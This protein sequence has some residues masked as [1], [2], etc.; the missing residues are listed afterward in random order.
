MDIDVLVYGV[1]EATDT[2]D[3]I[4]FR[5]NNLDPVFR[6]TVGDFH[7]IEAQAFG[8]SPDLVQSGAL[9]D[10]LTGESADSF[11]EV[12]SDSLE[13]GTDIWYARFHKDR[14][15]APVTPAVKQKWGRQIGEYVA[16]GD[17]GAGMFEG[18]F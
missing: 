5:A 3:D 1:D 10:S 13:V 4:R 6:A 17:L 7:D 2:L 8:G 18:L 16:F 14:L 11:V 15:M 12:T 9:R